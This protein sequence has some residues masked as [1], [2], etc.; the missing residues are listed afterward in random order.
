LRIVDGGG[1]QVKQHSR[2]QAL[3]EFALVLPLLVLLLMAIFDFGRLIYAYNTVS[4][5]ARAGARVAV[6]D[7]TKANIDDRVMQ[8][9]LGLPPTGVLIDYSRP[10]CPQLTDRKLGCES[11]VTVKYPWSPITPIIGRIIGPVSVEAT[12]KMPLEFINPPSP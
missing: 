3:A 11:V 12:A 5:A 8:T 1:Q 10:T 4:N 7:Q 6:I 9:L 2:G